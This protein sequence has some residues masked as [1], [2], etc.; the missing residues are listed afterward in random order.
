V[1]LNSLERKEVTVED[2]NVVA[3]R[4]GLPFVCG[5]CRKVHKKADLSANCVRRCFER[6]C[7]LALGYKPLWFTPSGELIIIKPTCEFESSEY[8]NVPKISYSYP[9]ENNVFMLSLH[10]DMII[11]SFIKKLKDWHEDCIRQAVGLIEERGQLNDVRIRSR[12]ITINGKKFVRP[13]RMF[14]LVMMK[15]LEVAS[16]LDWIQNSSILDMEWKSLKESAKLLVSHYYVTCG[17]SKMFASEGAGIVKVPNEI[18]S[19]REAEDFL[20]RLNSREKNVATLQAIFAIAD[21]SIRNLIRTALLKSGLNELEERLRPLPTLG[22]ST[23]QDA[24]VLL[25][26]ALSSLERTRENKKFHAKYALEACLDTMNALEKASKSTFGDMSDDTIQDNFYMALCSIPSIE[27]EI[28]IRRG[29]Q[30][31]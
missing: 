24:K 5:M 15:R 26:E 20:R 13:S 14:Y 3:A 29:L 18:H 25:E 28:A 10:M 7:E 2:P 9:I 1:P 21:I 17:K 6:A 4:L 23:M 22:D 19:V 16:A 27:Q 8:F 11:K 12:R 30:Y 31:M